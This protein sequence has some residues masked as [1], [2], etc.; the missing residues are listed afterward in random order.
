MLV[1]SVSGVTV[2]WEFQIVG[3]SSSWG[4]CDFS[5]MLFSG[6]SSFRISAFRK[7]RFL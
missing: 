7:S 6:I 2:F 5:E 3:I 4:F 1:C